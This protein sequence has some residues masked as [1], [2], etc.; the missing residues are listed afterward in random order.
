MYFKIS[1]QLRIFSVKIATADTN[2]TF[3]TEY[4]EIPCNSFGPMKIMADGNNGTEFDSIAD[5]T[6]HVLDTT[7]ISSLWL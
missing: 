1:F 5:L 2:A 4:S 7:S 6:G 3:S